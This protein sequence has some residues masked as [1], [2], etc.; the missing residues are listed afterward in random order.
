MLVRLAEGKKARPHFRLIC[1]KTTIAKLGIWPHFN[2]INIEQLH[3]SFIGRRTLK[4]KNYYI[5][6]EFQ[7]QSVEIIEFFCVNFL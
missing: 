7:F 6:K 5:Q 1:E 4:I 3:N 2:N